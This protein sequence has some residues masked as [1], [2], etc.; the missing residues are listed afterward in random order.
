MSA[1]FC[2]LLSPLS[3]SLVIT[4][5]VSVTVT[6]APTSGQPAITVNGTLNIDGVPV[7]VVAG[8]RDGDVT[9]FSAN[10]I[11]VRSRGRKESVREGRR[12][13]GCSL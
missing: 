10:N 5:D 9:V 1:Q 4:P 6:D 3:S 12:E 13:L 2:S 11:T 8:G 7:T